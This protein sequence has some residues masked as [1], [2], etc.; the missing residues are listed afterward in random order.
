MKHAKFSVDHIHLVS[1]NPAETAKWYSE[2]FEAPVVKS[3]YVKGALQTAVSFGD[4]L[5]LVRGERPEE[6]AAE[7]KPITWGIDHFGLSVSGNFDEFCSSLKQKG[8]VFSL[9]PTNI[10]PDTRIAFINAPD[11]V[12]VE[13]VNRKNP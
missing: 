9:D 5:V 10:N 11:G 2:K 3:G 1:P 6:K 8:V 4:F 12:S 7:K 13:L